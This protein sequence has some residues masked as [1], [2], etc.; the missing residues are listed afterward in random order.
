[1]ISDLVKIKMLAVNQGGLQ[2]T[3]HQNLIIDVGAGIDTDR[4]RFEQPYGTDSQQVSRTR[5][6]PNEMNGHARSLIELHCTTA[7]A[8]RQP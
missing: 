5:T 7:R 8:G 3:V 6:C 2:R 1:M 4:R